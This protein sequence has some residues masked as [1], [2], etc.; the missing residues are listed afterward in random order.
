MS[1][2]VGMQTVREEDHGRWRGAV[3]A[4]PVVCGPLS[5]EALI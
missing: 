5:Q 3:S 2:D 1:G 4:R